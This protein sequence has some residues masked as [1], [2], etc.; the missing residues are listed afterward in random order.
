MPGVS[1]PAP[2]RDASGYGKVY[3]RFKP[4]KV[5]RF[6][7][8][9]LCFLFGFSI[10][11]LKITLS[12]PLV[13]KNYAVPLLRGTLKKYDYFR[14][15][16]SQYGGNTNAMF[17]KIRSEAHVPLVLN[18]EGL[19]NAVYITRIV[20][21]GVININAESQVDA[22]FA[23]G[24][25]HAVDRMFQM[26]L[27]RRK[28]KGILSEVIGDK[29]ISSD[30]FVRTLNIHNIAVKDWNRLSNSNSNFD[31]VDDEKIIDREEQMSLLEAYTAGVNS[32]LSQTTIL[33]IDFYFYAN[34]PSLWNVLTK[35]HRPEIEPWHPIDTL[36][37]LRLQALEWSSGFEKEY[38][39][40]LLRNEIGDE[41]ADEIINFGNDKLNNNDDDEDV[42]LLNSAGGNAWVQSNNNIKS[43]NKSSM[44]VLDSHDIVSSQSR[45]YLNHISWNSTSDFDLTENQ[46]CHVGGTSEPGIP[47]VIHGH[48]SYI[49]WAL[50]AADTDTE[51]LYIEEVKEENGEIKV[52]RSAK[53]EGS[54]EWEIISTRKEII[55]VAP[56]SPK[57][58]ESYE[59]IIEVMETS[60]GPIINEAIIEANIKS[61]VHTKISK[62]STA[63]SMN[64]INLNAN[65]IQHEKISL[66]SQ[67]LRQPVDISFYLALSQA[68]S[69]K[70]FDISTDRLKAA[71]MYALFTDISGGIGY[72]LTGM[73]IYRQH[74]NSNLP[75]RG[76]DGLNW[77]SFN[78]MR[79][80]TKKSEETNEQYNSRST[81]IPVDTVVNQQK[82]I[83]VQ[84]KKLSSIATG[85]NK[86]RLYNRIK[87]IQSN[88][89]DKKISPSTSPQLLD[90]ISNVEE[91]L[92]DKF[93]PSSISLLHVIL[94]ISFDTKCDKNDQSEISDNCGHEE[95]KLSMIKEM[96]KENRGFDGI[97]TISAAP[98]G[99]LLEATILS[100][101][102][103]ILNKWGANGLSGI[104]QGASLTTLR[105]NP[106]ATGLLVV[107][108][109]II[110]A[111]SKYVNIN[112][113]KKFLQ[114]DS[115]EILL[116][117]N[118]L[119]AFNWCEKEFGPMSNSWSWGKAHQSQFEHAINIHPIL[120]EILNPPIEL[121]SG[122]TDSI[123]STPRSIEIRPYSRFYDDHPFYA[124]FNSHIS[125]MRMI[126][127][128]DGDH[129]IR[130][131]AT[132][133]K[134]Q[135]ER[136][137]SKWLQDEKGLNKWTNIEKTDDNK[138]FTED[139][140]LLT[141]VLFNSPEIKSKEE[142]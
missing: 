99:L 112:E 135:N 88:K 91:V 86:T 96:I 8:G 32:Y 139:T 45:W 35:G 58:K 79:S 101:E 130:S 136:L 14:G 5:K 104:L 85:G 113:K 70:E 107:R 52:K 22:I 73:P 56:T 109:W 39:S 40:A 78:D 141:P 100:L 128:I 82:T 105:R 42:I 15:I 115:L 59:V 120:H 66:C 46:N 140:Y 23:Q 6:P 44:L 95:K 111:L 13:R 80:Q 77:L 142:L 131:I 98:I 63:Q 134:G 122:T 60:N 17:H 4:R 74:H 28:A 9:A 92:D 3:I 11:L 61:G 108:S 24:Y 129:K 67:A 84:D 76:S 118:L 133:R 47:L 26:D 137:G 75:V 18:V 2:V 43:E 123:L 90:S 25:M 124:G 69:W 93:S 72:K 62:F 21:T 19:N 41:L 1:G 94:S 34:S 81:Y 50:I 31:S 12:Y 7:Y 65:S 89:N 27:S 127:G 36:S 125:N 110:N 103:D 87:M 117:R 29:G 38:S 83:I 71:T 68:K 116:R 30:K 138:L 48:N 132:V 16:W 126:T 53:N 37:L 114:D 97:Y 119:S 20:D 102:E 54:K 57:Y 10:L 55:T 64:N 51:D 49:G 121:L 33:P 106:S